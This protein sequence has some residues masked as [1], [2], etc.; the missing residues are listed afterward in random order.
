MPIPAAIAVVDIVLKRERNRQITNARESLEDAT[1]GQRLLVLLADEYLQL[2][3]SRINGVDGGSNLTLRLILNQVPRFT[4][5]TNRDGR[6]YQRS[7]TH[8]Y[9]YFQHW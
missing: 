3:V 7:P 2:H 4:N 8:S 9:S 6:T 5:Q 1:P